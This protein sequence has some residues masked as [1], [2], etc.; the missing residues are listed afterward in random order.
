[1]TRHATDNF[2]G[3]EEELDDVITFQFTDRNF[4]GKGSFGKIEGDVS[5]SYFL[6]QL[7]GIMARKPKWQKWVRARKDDNGN[8]TE[9]GYWEKVA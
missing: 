7:L 3:L 2:T 1:M 6:K 4:D 5:R 8:V 9:K